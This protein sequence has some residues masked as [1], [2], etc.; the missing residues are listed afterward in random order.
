MRSVVEWCEKNGVFIMHQGNRQLVNNCEFL[1]SFYKPYM[2]HLKNK[3]ENWKEL[4]INY[5]NG[6]L[7]EILS[8]STSKLPLSKPYKANS[9]N[10]KSFLQKLKDL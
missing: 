6:N 4:F 2:N 9:I 10:E 5:L 3:H 1:L 7:V 8:C